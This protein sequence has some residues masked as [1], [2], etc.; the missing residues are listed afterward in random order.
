VVG[1]QNITVNRKTKTLALLFE[2]VEISQPVSV[3]AKDLV[4]MIAPNNNVIKRPVIF[5]SGFSRHDRYYIK[6]TSEF[7]PLCRFA[8]SVYRIGN[9]RGHP[10]AGNR[11]QEQAD[12][13]LGLRVTSFRHPCSPSRGV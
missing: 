11:L 6:P 4:V 1:H 2:L 9:H 13:P 5:D 8:K 3:V 7:R 10:L 12:L